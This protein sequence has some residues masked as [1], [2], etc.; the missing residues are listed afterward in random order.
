MKISARNALKG[1]V[2]KITKGAVN[3]L[4]VIEI[5]KGIQI[6]SIITGESATALK[7]AKGKPAYAVIKASSVMIGVDE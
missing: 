2:V 7:L 5:A 4:V 6:T 3:T 1:K